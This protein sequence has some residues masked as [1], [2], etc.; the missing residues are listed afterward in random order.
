[1]SESP[2][3]RIAIRDTLY[4]SLAGETSA[5]RDADPLTILNALVQRCRPL[6]AND[7]QALAL[8]ESLAAVATAAGLEAALANA[9]ARFEAPARLREAIYF[10]RCLDRDA[11]AIAL[12]RARGYLEATR[13]PAALADLVTDR[14]AVLDATTFA[15]LWRDAGRLEW[16]LDAS[17]LWRRDYTTAYAAQ[18]ASYHASI[19]TIAE[20]VDGLS[21]EANAVRRLNELSRLGSPLAVEALAQFGEL[22]RL[23][24]CSR[25][26]AT[27][28]EALADAPVCPE[29][30]FEL[31]MQA[32]A[33]EARRVRTAIERGLAGQQARLAQRVVSKLLSRPYEDAEARVERFIQVVQAADLSGLALVLDDELLVFL[34]DLLEIDS[35]ETEI[36]DRLRRAF[37][38]ITQA[39]L[40]QAVAEFRA[41]LEYELPRSGGR[42]RLLPEERA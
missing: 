31:G 42:L 17:S 27:L 36:I 21:S 39:N 9:E 7:A 4:D 16:M 29:C 19:S 14:A 40:D 10:T 34:R 37:P 28:T 2:D 25:A 18:H 24:P 1:M 3:R 20:A 26:G 23:F 15:E 32:P 35:A 38:E 5:A 30:G 22:E 13:V 11:N 6:A 33:A 12:L 8:L 41:I